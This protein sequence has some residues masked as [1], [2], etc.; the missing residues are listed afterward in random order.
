MGTKNRSGHQK[1]RKDGKSNG[2]CRKDEEG[3][4]RGKSSIEKS[5]GENEKASR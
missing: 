2:V 3:I 4:R 5:A 1:E